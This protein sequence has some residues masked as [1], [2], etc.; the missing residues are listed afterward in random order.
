LCIIKYLH[1]LHIIVSVNKSIF[2]QGVLTF[3][4]D[5]FLKMTKS[6]DKVNLTAIEGEADIFD[7]V[8]LESRLYRFG[9]GNW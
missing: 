3:S 2:W 4:E 1:L 6:I 7:S 9:V 5:F 8:N